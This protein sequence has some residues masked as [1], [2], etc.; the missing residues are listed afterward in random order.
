MAS[1]ASRC[2]VR[3]VDECLRYSAL[4]ASS[5]S[6]PTVRRAGTTLAAIDPQQR[7]EAADEEGRAG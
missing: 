7:D 3:H 5:G 2:G 6:T 1:S 4:S